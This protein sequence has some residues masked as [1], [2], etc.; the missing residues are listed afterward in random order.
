MS[1]LYFNHG[2][3]GLSNDVAVT[4]VGNN[5][6]LSVTL[7]DDVS[8][9][10]G[11]LIMWYCSDPTNPG[12]TAVALLPVAGQGNVGEAQVGGAP[13]N[14][15][16]FLKASPGFPAVFTLQWAIPSSVTTSKIAFFFQAVDQ[17]DQGA[18]TSFSPGAQ[19]NAQ[20]NFSLILTPLA[21]VA[22]RS[23]D[24]QPRV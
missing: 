4:Q 19:L 12:G 20:H 2:F 18:P 16:L 22:P 15:T 11:Q 7:R 9:A 23:I 14:T 24:S 21:K 17:S 1:N 5:C 3:G 8:A 10:Y 13:G 6:N